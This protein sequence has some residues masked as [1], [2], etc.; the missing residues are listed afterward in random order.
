MSA[1]IIHAKNF[2]PK[3]ITYGNV[4]INKHG[5]KAI[6]L[7]YQGKP[8]RIQLPKM[9]MPFG[10]GAFEDASKN[11]KYSLGVSFG[12]DNEN[13]VEKFQALEE[14]TIDYIAEHSVEIFGKKTEKSIVVHMFKKFVSLST[15][16]GVPDGKYP[17]TFRAKFFVK[18]N[19]EFNV[20]A[21]SAKKVN[22]GYE[23]IK[24]DVDNAADILQKGMQC[25]T[26]MECTGIWVVGSGLG[27]GWRVAQMK[28]YE[29]ENK[30][31]STSAFLDDVDA[32]SL[33]SYAGVTSQANEEEEVGEED[34]EDDLDTGAI[35]VPVVPV[36]S[37]RRKTKEA[38]L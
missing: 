5:G 11:V 25:Q 1:T 35:V 33:Y 34:E 4:K 38:E 10:V 30:L 18:E 9:V 26:I 27:I 13:L 24:I 31:P 17:P 37:R 28:L 32:D 23:K 2:N 6:Y 21:F 14:K 29:N 19:G 36:K 7:G 16:D 12:D 8:L 3:E 20:D 15:T 22:G